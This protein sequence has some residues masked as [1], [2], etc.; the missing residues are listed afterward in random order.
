M[1]EFSRTHDY[2]DIMNL[3]SY[4][5]MNWGRIRRRIKLMRQ[6]R[7]KSFDAYLPY[8]EGKSGIEIGGP[9]ALF[10]RGSI[11]PIY[12]KI[13]NLDNC[14]FSQSTVWAKHSEG[15]IFDSKKAQGKILFCDGSNLADVRDG[16]Y[17]VVLSCHNLEHFANPVKALRE[18]QRILGPQGSLILVLP[19]YRETFDHLRTP[20]SVDH[21][22]DDFERNVGEDDLTHLAEILEKHDLKRD[23]LAGSKEEFH[24]RSLNNFSNRCLHHHVFDEKNSHALLSRAG[25]EVL[26]VDLA[27]PFHICILA[28]M[29]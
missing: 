19:N 8:L 25:F 10:K 28:R 16:S 24:N 15:F 6:G 27:F 20:T 22:F 13:G 26:T 11:L 3:S 17:D 4:K 23:P 1:L 7:L 12:E 2:D 21:M 9:S 18:W 29:V 5:K 14:D